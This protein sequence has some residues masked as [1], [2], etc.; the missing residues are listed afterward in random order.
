MGRFSVPCPNVR[1]AL[2]KEGHIKKGTKKES[3]RR[4]ERG[5]GGKQMEKLS[6]NR[7]NYTYIMVN[8]ILLSSLFPFVQPQAGR[9]AGHTHARTVTQVDKQQQQQ[10][11]QREGRKKE[12]TVTEKQLRE[13][14][15]KKREERLQKI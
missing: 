15:K 8:V 9:P 5:Q 6:L 12:G 10:L 3:G 11:F 4:E 2:E 13:S 7:L 1:S 14:S